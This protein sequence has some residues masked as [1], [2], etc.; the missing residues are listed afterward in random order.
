MIKVIEVRT[1]GLGL[2]ATARVFGISKNTILKWGIHSDPY[3][4]L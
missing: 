1:E 4:K 3:E 2:N